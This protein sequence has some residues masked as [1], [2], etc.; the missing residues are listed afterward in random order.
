MPFT[1]Y[2]VR[3]FVSL[4]LCLGLLGCGKTDSEVGLASG[5]KGKQV[6]RIEPPNDA[7][8]A[9]LDELGVTELQVT[10]A[11]ALGKSTLTGE[12]KNANGDSTGKHDEPDSPIYERPP[13]WITASEMP[14]E[15]WEVLYLGN[16]PIGYLHQLV[17]PSPTG[18]T[19]ILRIDADSFI[20]VSRE[21]KRFDQQ[22]NVTS[23]EETDG[24]LRTIEATIRQGEIETKTDGMVILGTLRLKT[25]SPDKA[26]G[27]DIPWPNEC[28]GPFAVAQSMRGRPMRPGETRRLL[29]L[30]PILGQVVKIKLQAKDYIKTPLIDGDQYSLLEI[31][32]EARFGENSLTSTLWTNMAGETLKSYTS[33][34]DIRSFRV[35]RSLAESIRDA[36][37]CERLTKTQI[38][39]KSPIENIESK[40][41][42][43]FQ[44]GHSE[45]DPFPMLPGR[46]NQSIKSTS[47][48]TVLA[49]VFAMKERTPMP[50]GVSPELTLDPLCSQPSNV[51][52]SDDEKVKKIADQFHNDMTLGMSVLERLR[53]GVYNWIETKTDYTPT[54]SS[55]AEVVRDRVGDSTEHA[56]LLAAVVRAQGVPSRV[57]F[58]LVYNESKSD[59][60]LVFHAWT[61]VYLKDHWVSIDASVENAYTNASYVKLVDSP[62]ADQNPY[63]P[64]LAALKSIRD[65][66]IAV[67]Y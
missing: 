17:M 62:L 39:L 59:P 19:G 60:A 44:I 2:A 21:K 57:A 47:A 48:F 18:A 63:A 15:F 31:T 20:R 8:K 41:K 27:I 51:I 9:V 4:S 12:K 67:V 58:G 37:E 30:D 49:T 7:G 40:E 61:E 5:S 14:Y 36:A 56:T 23:I 45:R 64:L 24:R 10:P 46:T 25:Q 50:I 42:L 54:M 22:L 11:E 34:W 29:M 28:G 33:V 52:Q 38:K 3:R 26:T 43:E 16:R 32:S 13:N 65:F 66:E 55:A 53:R 6:R 1:R 35:E